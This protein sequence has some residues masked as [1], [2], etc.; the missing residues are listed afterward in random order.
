MSNCRQTIGNIDPVL[1]V[2]QANSI[3]PD[4]TDTYDLGSTSKEYKN[5][6]AQNE[7]ITNLTAGTVVATSTQNATTAG[8]TGA[9]QASSGGISS[10]QDIY[11]GGILYAAST[12]NATSGSTGA[13]ITP[14]GI[15]CAKGVNCD[16]V[17]TAGQATLGLCIVKLLGTSPN[18]FYI[19][20]TGS[21]TIAGSALQQN[22]DGRTILNAAT[23]QSIIFSI[24]SATLMTLLAASLTSTVAIAAPTI[25]AG[26]I[27]TSQ[28]GTSYTLV[29]GDANSVIFFTNAAAI[30]LTFPTNSNVAF[31]IGTYIDI[32]QSSTGKVSFAGGGIT[33]ES[34]NNWTSTAAQNTVVRAL[35]RATDTWFLYGSLGV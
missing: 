3:I 20:A 32:V 18:G 24:N 17:N 30:T 16:T 15:G 1:A 35:K 25:Q 4:R 29:L 23:G 10:A 27:I 9:I 6:Y 12:T 7:V 19:S 14:G 22:A 26:Q 2:V 11:S 34:Q 5:L 31:P 8:T 28:S 13:I 21:S 33:Y